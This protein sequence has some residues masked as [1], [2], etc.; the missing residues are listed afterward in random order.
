MAGKITHRLLDAAEFTKSYG[1][2]YRL[3]FRVTGCQ[4]ML[5]RC[6]QGDCHFHIKINT[7]TRTVMSLHPCLPIQP[8]AHKPV[9]LVREDG[10]EVYRLAG[11]DDAL[12]KLYSHRS[13]K[14]LA[15]DVLMY[16]DDSGIISVTAPSKLAMF[17][18]DTTEP[19]NKI[20]RSGSL[21]EQAGNKALVS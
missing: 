2:G 17:E 20:N 21:M 19:R 3:E 1:S 10:V 4:D 18:A 12:E 7:A 13:Y 6:L 16:L 15:V 14:R 5:A 11:R 8:G 9:R